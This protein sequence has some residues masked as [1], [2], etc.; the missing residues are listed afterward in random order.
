MSP[1]GREE[2]A[3]VIPVGTR[4]VRTRPAAPS[5]GVAGA[6]TAAVPV[7]GGA[8]GWT[9]RRSEG[10]HPPRRIPGR[11][12]HAHMGRGTRRF[13]GARQMIYNLY[14]LQEDAA[15]LVEPLARQAS[16]WLRAWDT[17]G[18]E[19]TAL[20]RVAGVFEV[21]ADAGPTHRKPAFGLDDV[22]VGGRRVEVREEEV[23][24]SPFGRLLRFAKGVADPGPPVL[25]VPPLSG[26][27]ATRVRG[28][29]AALLAE[30]DV[31][32]ADWTDAREVP[33]AAGPFGLDELVASI[34]AF[35]RAI[36]PGAHLLTVSQPGVAALAATALM[37]E[38][39]CPERPRSLTLIAGPVDTRVNPNRDHL[40]ARAL[41]LAWFERNA[42][43]T[44]P[45]RFPG[46]GRRVYPGAL[47]L[48]ATLAKDPGR[49]TGAGFVRLHD[50]GAGDAAAVEAH[51]R[52]QDEFRSVMDVAAELYLDTV[53]RVFQEHE[54]PLGRM[55]W[56]G[57]PVRPEAIQDTVVFAVEGEGD[58]TCPPGQ[59][60][61]ALDLCRGLDPAL[62]RY[63]LQAGADHYALFEGP[64]WEA[65]I[66][67]AVRAAI[68][69]A[70]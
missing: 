2:P 49:H 66:Y 52:A 34:A 58:E 67:R 21:M 55:T 30:H 32:V 65:E 63:H 3:R 17:G 28:T 1:R 70:G 69:S 46:A 35:L 15:T 57:R 22:R 54:L 6:T 48:A 7:S 23:L 14:Q 56:R 24:A 12:A 47:M 37:A 39:G 36:G 42:T 41:P 5:P 62:K 16:G 61:A 29:V 4:P 45:E 59:T 27:F 50:I 68:R 38:D 40:L 33:A 9:A 53:R 20:R 10:K 25:V 51:R 11:G 31:H 18:A 13:G 26:H 64:V 60:R 43:A 44:V 8:G 19:A